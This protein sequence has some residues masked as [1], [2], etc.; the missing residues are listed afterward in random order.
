MLYLCSLTL[1][2][3]FFNI[4]YLL[5]GK[6][7]KTQ[8]QGVTKRCRPSWLTISAIL[9]EPKC[10]GK[11]EGSQPM[12][13]VQLCTWS[14]NKL[15]RSNS[16]F[17]LCSVSTVLRSSKIVVTGCLCLPSGIDFFFKE[18]YDVPRNKESPLI[19]RE[20]I[21]R[22]LV[23][24]EE[25]YYS[26]GCSLWNQIIFPCEMQKSKPAIPLPLC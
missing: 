15:W 3:V 11:R 6:R 23:F 2:V 22:C 10:G 13:T 14:P 16:I 24:W 7:L 18:Y 25:R 20:L 4:M 5:G 9:Y 8:L 17:N 26:I 12:S 19:F 1:K 21:F